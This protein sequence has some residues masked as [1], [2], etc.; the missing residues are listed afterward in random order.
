[1]FFFIKEI[2][3]LKSFSKQ[4]NQIIRDHFI[5]ISRTFSQGTFYAVKIKNKLYVRMIMYIMYGFLIYKIFLVFL[6]LLV[7]IQEKDYVFLIIY[8]INFRERNYFPR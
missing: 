5:N 2:F 7:I 3:V 1:M 4:L 6:L 8:K